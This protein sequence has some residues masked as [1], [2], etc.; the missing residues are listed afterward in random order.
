MD[1]NRTIVL[2]GDMNIDII[3]W[4]NEEVVSY[5]TTLMSQQSHYA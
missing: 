3:K 4:S 2:A 1:D 5:M